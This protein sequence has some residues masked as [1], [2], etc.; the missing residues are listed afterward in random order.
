V[1]GKP[2]GRRL[3]Q[4]GARVGVRAGHGGARGAARAPGGG[5]AAGRRKKGPDGWA[6]YGDERGREEGVARW[7]VGPLWAETTMRLGFRN[8]LFSFYFL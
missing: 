2:R 6:P 8:C 3:V 4:A 1:H 7:L 5:S